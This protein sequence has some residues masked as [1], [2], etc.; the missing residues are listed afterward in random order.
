MTTKPILMTTR[1]SRR[2][3]I[4]LK[5]PNDIDEHDEGEE[6]TLNQKPKK[7]ACATKAY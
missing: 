4:A 5:T 7:L 3:P 6:T 1:I 2:L